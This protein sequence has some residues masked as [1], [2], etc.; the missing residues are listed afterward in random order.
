[1]TMLCY[2]DKTCE[3][4]NKEEII[5]NYNSKAVTLIFFSVLTAWYSFK[6]IASK[7]YACL[8]EHLH[9]LHINN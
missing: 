3:Q 9:F 5:F 8:P 2:Y 4:I 7:F 1:M 6:A